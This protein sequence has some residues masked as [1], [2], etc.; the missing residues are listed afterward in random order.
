M[1]YTKAVF[2]NMFSALAVVILLG[3]VLKLTLGKKSLAVRQIPLHVIGFSLVVFEIVKQTVYIC[4]GTW[5]T[6][7][8]PLHFC[9][10]FLIWFA[11]ALVTRGRLRQLM[12]FCS[13]TGGVIMTVVL[14]FS[15]T[16]VLPEASKNFWDTF[17][18]GHSYFF[19]ISVFS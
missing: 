9:S 19:H 10:F 15:P 16:A 17:E 11:V 6:W 4:K 18:H 5:N 2:I 13:L 12:Y 8:L 14:Y 3:V 1:G 7:C